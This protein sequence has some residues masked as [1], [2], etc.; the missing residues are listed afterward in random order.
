MRNL[1]LILASFI[2]LVSCTVEPLSTNENVSQN[3]IPSTSENTTNLNTEIIPNFMSAN[4]NGIQFNNLKP[5][6]YVDAS[7]K[8]VTIET[9]TTE[10]INYKY[11]LIQGS[12][13]TMN[14]F[15]SNESLII[16][17][18]IPQ[19]QWN[20]GT[21]DLVSENATI[22]NGSKSSI[23]FYDLGRGNK[24]ISVEQGSIRVTDFDIVAKRIKGNFNITYYL[25]TN[26]DIVEGP[27]T[28]TNGTFNYEL[29]DPYFQ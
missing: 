14:S 6:D 4:I 27:F 3:E 7:T 10:G 8:Q 19:S 26:N 15:A 23:G 1:S 18:R 17:L 5:M 29:D 20:V 2:T 13:I 16:N 11:L 24:T 12:N 9:Y 25:I 28:L 21:Y 22:M